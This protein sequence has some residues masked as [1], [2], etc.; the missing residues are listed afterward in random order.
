MAQDAIGGYIES[1]LAH[2]EPIPVESNPAGPVLVAVTITTKVQT[3][4]TAA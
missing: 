1:L 4:T 3:Q 2:N